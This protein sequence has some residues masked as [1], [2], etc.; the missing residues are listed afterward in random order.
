MQPY[1]AKI[2]FGDRNGK[3]ENFKY[4][5]GSGMLT[6][7]NGSIKSEYAGRLESSGDESEPQS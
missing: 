3:S 2:K 6:S 1:R 4:K 5:N 7:I